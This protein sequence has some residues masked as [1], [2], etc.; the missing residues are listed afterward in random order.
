MD[1]EG[2]ISHRGHLGSC[3]GENHFGKDLS[4]KE[5]AYGCEI[6]ILSHG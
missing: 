6:S 4:A 1:E 2:V 3:S 5:R